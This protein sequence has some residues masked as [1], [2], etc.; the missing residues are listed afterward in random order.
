MTVEEWIL[1]ISFTVINNI[2]LQVA[3]WKLAY[4]LVSKNRR[5][6]D[7]LRNKSLKENEDE[8]DIH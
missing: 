5:H 4:R 1:F 7:K 3:A 6:M 2:V 8:T